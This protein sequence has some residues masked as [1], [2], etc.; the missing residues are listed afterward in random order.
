MMVIE[1]RRGGRMVGEKLSSYDMSV[2]ETS[3]EL[4]I[5]SRH[6]ADELIH[7]HKMSRCNRVGGSNLFVIAFRW[8]DF[9]RHYYR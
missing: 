2:C 1:G 4:G 8:I 3:S 6:G 9:I 5:D 7:R